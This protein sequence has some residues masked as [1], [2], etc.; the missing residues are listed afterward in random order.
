MS[1]IVSTVTDI[2]TL[3]SDHRHYMNKLD[4]TKQYKSYYSAK[5]KP[6]LVYIEA[7]QYLSITGKGDPSSAAFQQDIQALYSVA[8]AIKFMCKEGGNDFTVAKL[9]GD[10]WYDEQLYAGISGEDTPSKIPR[11]EWLYRLMIRLPEFVQS[12][13]IE[14]AQKTAIEKKGIARAAALT[15]HTTSAHEAAQM[16][17]VGP[18]DKEP[19]TIQRIINFMRENSLQKGGHHHEIY[20]SDFRK[21]AVEKLRTILREPVKG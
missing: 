7:A 6:E 17:H 3:H 12:N 5:T 13:Q 11:S 14:K 16:M 20:L 18:F 4:L 19:E 9:E 1:V 21:T 15:Q 2:V 10:W 8:Y